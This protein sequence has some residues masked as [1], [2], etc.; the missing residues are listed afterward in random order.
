MSNLNIQAHVASLELLRTLRYVPSHRENH[1]YTMKFK[2]ND[3]PQT[4]DITFRQRELYSVESRK[5][6]DFTSSIICDFVH[7]FFSE[8]YDKLNS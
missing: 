2:V 8:H 5:K 6:H 3:R 7:R 4:Y 1:V